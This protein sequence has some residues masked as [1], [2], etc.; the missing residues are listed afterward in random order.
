MEDVE[1][2]NINI[3]NSSLEYCK[4]W[5]MSSIYAEA[6]IEFTASLIEYVNKFVYHSGNISFKI[7]LKMLLEFSIDYSNLLALPQDAYEIIN[8]EI[9]DEEITELDHDEF[10]I[11]VSVDEDYFRDR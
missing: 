3:K 1:I 9:Y 11:D 10:D 4:E 8:C 6:E 5:E 7:E 2:Q